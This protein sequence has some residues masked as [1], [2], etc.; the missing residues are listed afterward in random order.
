MVQFQHSGMMTF[1]HLKHLCMGHFH[2]TTLFLVQFQHS[3]VMT[4]LH[5]KPLCLITWVLSTTSHHFILGSV[6]TFKCDDLSALEHL[7]VNTLHHINL[8]LVPFQHSN[9]ITFLHLNIYASPP[10]HLKQGQNPSN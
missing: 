4:F 5:L 6:S 1:L 7:C 9:M 2:H 10:P 3:S 8:S